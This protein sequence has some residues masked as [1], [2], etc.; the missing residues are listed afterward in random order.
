M[1][2]APSGGAS[3]RPNE[4][5]AVPPGATGYAS[6]S[7][8]S[9]GVNSQP[10]TPRNVGS[11]GYA[12][13]VASANRALHLQLDQPVHLH[14]V[15][16]RQLLDDRLDESV[17][18]E[19][20]GLVLGD[21]VGHEVEELLLADLRDRRLVTDVDVVL[22]DA[23]GRVGVRARVLVQQQRVAHDLRARAVR[24]L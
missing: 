18:D 13:A 15:L 21:A 6:R 19:L 16:H 14:G 17:D 8:L 4:L 22:A 9:I 3:S 5:G 11:S 1:T 10:G 24:A 2:M 12:A 20:A 23:D 7:S